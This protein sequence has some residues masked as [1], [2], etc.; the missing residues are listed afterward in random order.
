MILPGQALSYLSA[1]DASHIWRTPAKAFTGLSEAPCL[2]GVWL[3]RWSA[4]CIAKLG[5]IDATLL[6]R[7]ISA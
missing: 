3:G 5:G 6:L 4:G 7:Q 2:H 1:L